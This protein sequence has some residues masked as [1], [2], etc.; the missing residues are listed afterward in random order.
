[1][2]SWHIAVQ[3]VGAHNNKD[4]PQDADR[5]TEEFV[6]KLVDAGH[7]VESATF[8]HGGKVSFS[9]VHDN[10]SVPSSYIKREY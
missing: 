3:G 1:M 6:Q 8:T 4:Y 5:M 7:Q 2:G 9:V 10:E